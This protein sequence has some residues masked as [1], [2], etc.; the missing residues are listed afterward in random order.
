VEQRVKKF[1]NLAETGAFQYHVDLIRR[2]WLKNRRLLLLFIEIIMSFNVIRSGSL[3]IFCDWHKP[4][5]S[6]NEIY[7]RSNDEGV[8]QP[9]MNMLSKNDCRFFSDHPSMTW[10]I[11]ILKKIY[12]WYIY[13]QSQKSNYTI[14]NKIRWRY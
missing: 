11:R 7:R 9:T 2:Q 12:L 14:V 10:M 4:G 5:S 13:N 8:I 6:S 3:I 1:E